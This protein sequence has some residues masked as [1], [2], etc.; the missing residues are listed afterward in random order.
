MCVIVCA[1]RGGEASRRTQERAVALAK[2][3]NQEL[4]FL[5][6]VDPS[7]AGPLDDRT[8]AALD[9]ELKRLGRALLNIAQSRAQEQDV[10]SRTICIIG[11]VWENIIA[12]LEEMD[13]GTLVIGRPRSN[14]II[15]AFGPKDLSDFA[16]E[17]RLS[18]GVEVVFV[19]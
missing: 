15:Q 4:I 10:G 2:E 9:D 19:T 6:I 16:D 12:Y 11:K 14:E 8:A 1:T 18:T 7:F 3:R 5:C 13:C 17:V